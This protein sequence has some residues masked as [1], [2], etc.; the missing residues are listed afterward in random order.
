M[1]KIR[2]KIGTIGILPVL[3]AIF[4]G[5]PTFASD[6]AAPEV[7]HIPAGSYFIGSNRAEKEL[8]Y[9]LDEAAYGHSVT[10]QQKWYEDEPPLSERQG[11]AYAITQTLITNRQYAE[12]INQTGHPTPN[13]DSATWRSYGLIHPF[14]RTRRHAWLDGQMPAGREDHP[15]VLV[16]FDDVQAYAAW[17]SRRTGHHWRLPSEDD[18]ERAARGDEGKIFPWGNEYDPSRLNSHDMGPFDT[19]PVGQYSKGNSQHGLVDP[20]GQVFEWTATAKGKGRHIVKG[21]SWDDK[22]CGVCRPAAH[23]S[24]PDHLKHILIG[25]RLVRE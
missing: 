22:G 6:L 4:V 17:L 7:I 3:A 15:V 5:Q 18:W 14:T 8:A 19:V 13:V 10:R 21:G 24:R 23:H 2:C 25:F 20:A 11:K 1:Q 12:F 16:S 9:M